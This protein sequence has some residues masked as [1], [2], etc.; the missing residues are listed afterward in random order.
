MEDWILNVVPNAP[1]LYLLEISENCKVSWCFQ[2]VEKGAL[3]P[4]GLTIFV[5]SIWNHPF[6]TH[7]F[8]ITHETK[9]WL[10]NKG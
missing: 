9:H 7:P 5:F 2:G 3:G 10:R 1:F 4:N 6:Y 8:Q